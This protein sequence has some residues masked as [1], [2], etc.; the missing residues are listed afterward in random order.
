[1]CKYCGE[2]KGGRAPLYDDYEEYV[3]LENT[4]EEGYW[5]DVR[6]DRAEFQIEVNYCPIC[7]KKLNTKNNR[8]DFYVDC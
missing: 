4:K 7:G 3:Y 1:M 6:A 8:G 2:I 5:L